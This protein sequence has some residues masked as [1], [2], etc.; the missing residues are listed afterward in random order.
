[1]TQPIPWTWLQYGWVWFA[2]GSS[3][4]R[5]TKTR[6]MHFKRWRM[7]WVNKWRTLIWTTWWAK[8]NYLTTQWMRYLSTKRWW[9]KLWRAIML[10]WKAQLLT[11]CYKCW[12]INLPWKRKISLFSLRD[13]LLRN[14]LSRNKPKKELIAPNKTYRK[15]RNLSL[16]LSLNL[17]LN[18]LKINLLG[19]ITSRIISMILWTKLKICDFVIIYTD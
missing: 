16:S 19:R 11:K 9:A 2:I 8:C 17:N 1:M 7:W 14:K 18:H 10:W 3:L 13:P 4:W 5:T 15:L 6:W 12:R